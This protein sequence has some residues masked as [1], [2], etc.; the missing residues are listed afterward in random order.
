MESLRMQP[1]L[2]ITTMAVMAA[3]TVVDAANMV[4]DMAKAVAI[5]ATADAV[6]KVVAG[7]AIS[8]VRR[9]MLSLN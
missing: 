8:P 4:A 6:T 5:A 3:D 7:A 9:P 2:M 1:A